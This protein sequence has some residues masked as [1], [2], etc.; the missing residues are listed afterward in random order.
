MLEHAE[1][2]P[3]GMVTVN[4]RAEARYECRRRLPMEVSVRPRFSSFWVVVKDI[5][6]RGI[7]LLWEAP[8]ESGNAILLRPKPHRRI[9]RG[10]V[11]HV[12]P[13]LWGRW[14]IG[15]TLAEALTADELHVYAPHVF[16]R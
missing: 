4:R 15:C 10:L 13:Y 16:G 12:T 14:L 1:Q 2:S 9:V 7:G 8:I 5:G 3:P 11:A 6:E